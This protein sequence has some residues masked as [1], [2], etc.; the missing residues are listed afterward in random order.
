MCSWCYAFAPVLEQLRQQLP[1]NIKFETLLGGLAADTDTPMPIAMQKQLQT[2]W[3]RI[4]QKVPSTVFNYHFWAPS[5]RTHP[6][7]ATYPACRSVIAAQ[8]F[9]DHNTKNFQE[10]M[11]NAIQLAYYQQARNPSEHSI[12]I[13]LAQ[14]I[15]L[16]PYE[17]ETELLNERT[18][19]E[20][21]RQIALSRKL[22]VSSYPSLIFQ[23]DQSYWPISVDYLSPFPMLE[24][25]NLL[26]ELKA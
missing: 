19:L 18:Q 14:E 15:G 23:I 4:E 13:Q 3:Q 17:F 7:R 25:I 1:E 2:T 24:T 16:D 6:R 20:L 8:S 22:N 12:L 21:E 9:N 5:A 10:L 11:T 26:Q